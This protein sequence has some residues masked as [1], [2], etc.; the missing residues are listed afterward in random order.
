MRFVIAFRDFLQ[1]W[2]GTAVTVLAILGALY[3]GP[4]KLLETWDWYWDR[5]RDNDVFHL[6]ARRKISRSSSRA[7]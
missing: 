7:D 4:R 5:Y 3:Y 1:T 2:Q 6:I